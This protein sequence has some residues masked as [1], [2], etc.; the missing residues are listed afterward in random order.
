MI[1]AR[2]I[3]KGAPNRY[4]AHL[5]ASF[6]ASEQAQK[7]WEKYNGH[8]SAFIP[9]SNTYKFFQ[10]KQALFMNQG[11]AHTVDKLGRQYGKILGFEG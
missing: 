6:L 2:A 7:I 9:G 1:S 3:Y 4:T 11:Q 10:G 8:A 5:F